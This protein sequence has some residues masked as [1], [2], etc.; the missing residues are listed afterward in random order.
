MRHS[1]KDNYL[2]LTTT[3]VPRLIVSLA[4]PTIISMLVTSFYNMADTYFVG[5]I[6]TQSTA[7][8]GIVFSVMS[9]IQAVG[10]FFGHGSGNY[11]SRKLGAQE[12]GNA[13][14]MAATGFFWALFMGI[15]LAVV[16]LIF[17]TPLSLALGSTPTILPYTEKYL[18]IILL[19]A[20]FMTA[21]L[22][23][24]NQIR[25]QGNAAY[26]MVGIVSG[27]VI[28]VILDPILIFVFDMGISGAALATVISQI[29][30]FSLLLYMG[31]K[32]GNIRIRFK[33]FTPSLAFIKEII[34]GGT[35]SLARQGLASV[36]TILLNVAAGAYGDA[37]IA[38]M[39]IVTRIA[40]FINAFLIGFGQGFQPVCGFNYGAGLYA[41]V[42]QG[43]WFCV[44]VGFIFLLVCALAG[45]GF[46]EEIVSLF[47]KGDPDVIAV[48]AA[49]LR[50]QFITFPLGSW[51]VMSNM[52][53]QTIRKPVKATIISS[54]RQGLFFIPLIF[55]LSHYLGLQGVEMCQAV[56]DLLTFILAIPLTC[57]V[58]NEM[59]RKQAEQL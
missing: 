9:I 52:M 28:N 33:N 57:S 26:A 12:T 11:I 48:G 2:Y 29:C 58:L 7:A 45:M 8:V 43:F 1:T 23:L 41:R 31:R 38:G 44:K 6:N 27:A 22:V 5:K 15:F 37:A 32:G 25:F 20:P 19:G 39:S 14:K 50:W 10:F 46:A 40:M 54:A 51:I 36:A 21:S 47:R 34:G 59:K 3:P 4:V 42:R 35:P 13:E 17:L 53:L 18:G 24:N 30:S 49:A 16:G 55:I 56:A